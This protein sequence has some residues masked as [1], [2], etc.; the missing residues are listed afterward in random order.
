VRFPVVVLEC[1]GDFIEV[2]LL[3]SDILSPS[4]QPNIVGSVAFSDS[5]HWHSRSDVEW[6]VDVEAEFLV[7]SLCSDFVSLIDVDNLPSLVFSTSLLVVSVGNSDS[8][9][10]FVL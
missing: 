10:F 2:P 8:L 9:T 4:L 5:L 6:S 3:G 7:E 1:L